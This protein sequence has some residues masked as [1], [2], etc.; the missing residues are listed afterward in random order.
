MSAKRLRFG[1]GRFNSK[2]L[3]D[4]EF[5]EVKSEA[6]LQLWNAWMKLWTS[7]DWEEK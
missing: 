6:D 5:K 4:M 3:N 7:I 2:K 1:C